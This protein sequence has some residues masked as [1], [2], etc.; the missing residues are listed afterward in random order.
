MKNAKTPF[1][2]FGLAVLLTAANAS[3]SALFGPRQYMRTTGAPNIYTDSFAC[4]SGEGRL[5]IHNGAADDKHRVT[6]ALIFVNGVQLLKPDDFK[7]QTPVLEIPISLGMENEL[8]VELRSMPGT[9]L[10]IEIAGNGPPPPTVSITADPDVISFGICEGPPD[11][12]TQSNADTSEPMAVIRVVVPGKETTLTWTSAG[13]DTCVIT[14]DVG[15]VDLSGATVVMPPGFPQQTTTYTITAEGPGGIAMADV[16]VEVLYC[17]SIHLQADS[18]TIMPGESTWIRWSSFWADACDIQ[19]GIGIVNPN[20]SLNVSPTETTTYII[21]A[22]ANGGKAS[23]SVTIT[24]SDPLPAA[25]LGII[26]TTIDLGEP[27]TLTWESLNATTCGIG[28]DIGPVNLSGTLTVYPAENTNYTLT[29]VGPGGTVTVQAAVS[30]RPPAASISADPMMIRGGD[31]ATLIWQATNAVA[32]EITP[33]VGSV[34][35][36]GSAVVTPAETTTYTITAQGPGGSTTARTT[37]T[38]SAPISLTITSPVANAGISRPDVMVRG[39]VD[40][41]LGLETGVTVNGRIAMVY[42]NQFVADHIPL[43]DGPNTITALAVDADGNTREASVTVIADTSADYIRILANPDSGLSPRK[44]FFPIDG[45]FS[46]A[47]SI[48]TCADPAAADFIEV[49]HDAHTALITGEGF[50]FF[51]AAVLS[52]QGRH[53]TDMTAVLLVDQTAI[54]ALLQARW[55]SMKIWLMSGDIE[56]A[57]QYFHENNKSKYRDIFHALADRLPDIAAQMRPITLITIAS[58]RAEYRLKRVE[59]VQGASYD[60][61]YGVCF[62]QNNDGLW[63]IESF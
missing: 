41:T 5:I 49:S 21:T 40:N 10:S 52:P 45:S 4:P 15:T 60:I 57:L 22:T 55:N 20:G 43:Q 17:P 51:T 59:T 8:Y 29:A 31:S 44:T 46:I 14:P 39:T 9:Y 7:H 23:D 12:E 42:Q 34:P 19:P 16:T 36:D 30:I 50:Y 56:A 58:G 63:A 33:D 1:L 2:I 47:D 24:V 61:S 27:A 13:A 53:L 3:G 11:S 26:P 6:S 54:D 35:S 62:T 48:V 37:V 28:P 32:C 18:T 38:V 25:I